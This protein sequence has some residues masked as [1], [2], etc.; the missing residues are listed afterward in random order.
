M[1]EILVLG[2]SY[3]AGRVFSMLA[4]R[5]KDVQLHV[6]NRGRYA[7]NM[8]HV[9]EYRCDRH[10]TEKLSQL[11]PQR[12]FDALID[13]C[14][15]N[16]GEIRGVVDALGERI[17]HYVYI[18]TA[19]VYQPGQGLLTEQAPLLKHTG[20]GQVEE[21]LGGKLALE[22][23]LRQ[24]CAQIP[25]TIVRPAFIYGPFNYAPREAWYI[26]LL[27]LMQP[28]PVPT[29]ASG[30]WSFVYVADVAKALLALAGAEKA[31]GQAYN[32]A[33]P[34]VMDYPAFMKLLEY[35]W[36]KPI[37]TQEITC[38]QAD[39]EMVPLPFPFQGE[40]CYS[41][42]KLCRDFGFAYTPLE[43]GM[44][45]TIAAFRPVFERG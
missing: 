44:E 37:K 43:Q 12:R 18:S 25:W 3:F 26:R 23:E 19:S 28:V 40:E 27:S 32:L 20:S 4:S 7:L 9:T 42:E 31:F 34:E 1:K 36:G 41:G 13:F 35:C 17:G 33:G 30:R 16:A 38:A 14:A 22:E 24:V 5:E 6:V 8:E 10:D 39:A 29:D 2:G 45:K 21:Y 11:L 15:Y